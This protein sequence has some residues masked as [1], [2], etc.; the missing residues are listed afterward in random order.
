MNSWFDQVKIRSTV[1][2]TFYNVILL[3][4]LPAR[5]G[6]LPKHKLLQNKK[7]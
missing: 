4:V 7:K 2:F 1:F 6:A 5:Y 3:N